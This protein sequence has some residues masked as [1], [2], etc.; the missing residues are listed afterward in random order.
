MEGNFLILRLII[1]QNPRTNNAFIS[2]TSKVFKVEEK[3][4]MPT[5]LVSTQ[6]F[7][8]GSS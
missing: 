2:K 8:E 6:H 5:L 1:Y 7:T 4:R 3:E